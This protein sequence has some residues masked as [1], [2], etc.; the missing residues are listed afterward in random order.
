MRQSQTLKTQSLRLDLVAMAII[1][2]VILAAAW[3]VYDGLEEQFLKNSFAYA[4]NAGVF[5]DSELSHAQEQLSLFAKVP[6]AQR[7]TLAERGFD[8]FSD[9][10][11]LDDQG[12]VT[13][14]YKTNKA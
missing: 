6:A 4:S 5:I 1:I 8:T 9:L 12:R 14:I 13:T 7:R 2:A 3:V 11:A 10:Y